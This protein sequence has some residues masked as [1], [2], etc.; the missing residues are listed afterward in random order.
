MTTVMAPPPQ[1]GKLT[2]LNIT[3]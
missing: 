2:D 1:S 3:N